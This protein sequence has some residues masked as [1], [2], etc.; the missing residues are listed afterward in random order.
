MQFFVMFIHGRAM[1][2]ME[3]KR[4]LPMHTS[5]LCG[6]EVV[7]IYKKIT[8]IGLDKMCGAHS[9]RHCVCRLQI[10]STSECT[11]CF[12]QRCSCLWE[13]CGVGPHANWSFLLSWLSKLKWQSLFVNYCFCQIHQ[14]CFWIWFITSIILFN[15]WWYSIVLNI[16][17]I[18]SKNSMSYLD[19]WTDATSVTSLMP[20]WRWCWRK[21]WL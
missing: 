4:D 12:S 7:F 8:K 1:L 6:K 20:T 21:W 13:R 9:H 2:A 15:Q 18:W 19:V 16:G 11:G 10:G 17:W 14:L 3:R 5:I